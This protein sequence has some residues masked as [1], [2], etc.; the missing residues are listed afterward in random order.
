MV[1]QPAIGLDNLAW[2]GGGCKNLSNESVRIQ[3]NG[4]YKLL[5]CFRSQRYGLRSL[6][7]ILGIPSKL[8]RQGLSRA[9]SEHEGCDDNRHQRWL[10]PDR[11]ECSGGTPERRKQKR[12]ASNT[13]VPLQLA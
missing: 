3:R 9:R 4:R 10:G 6:R 11:C 5:Q 12:C 13:E 1:F 8:N 2:I 7:N